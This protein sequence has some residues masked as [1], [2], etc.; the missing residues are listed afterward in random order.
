MATAVVLVFKKRC[1]TVYLCVNVVVCCRLSAV[2]P[3]CIE[4]LLF[5]LLFLSTMTICDCC[6]ADAVPKTVAQDPSGWSAGMTLTGVL[7]VA[8][9]D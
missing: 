1:S 3:V 6:P 8:L 7:L 9:G 5:L 4:K 2:P